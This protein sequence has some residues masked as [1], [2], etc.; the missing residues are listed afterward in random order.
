MPV[1]GLKAQNYLFLQAGGYLGSWCAQY[2]AEPQC[3]YEQVVLLARS[4][5][6]GPPSFPGAHQKFYVF[7][8]CYC[9][10]WFR[11]WKFTSTTGQGVP[12]DQSRCM[13]AS[14][15]V[16]AQFAHPATLLSDM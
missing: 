14:Q 7:V 6:R 15:R 10:I 2:A 16:V 3:R 13:R 4:L 8:T 9:A 12:S 1:T 11:E 5:G